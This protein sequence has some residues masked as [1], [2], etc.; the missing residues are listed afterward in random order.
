MLQNQEKH[1]T[2][3]PNSSWAS[4]H[5]DF[6][7][8]DNNYR[9]GWELCGFDYHQTKEW[10]NAGFRPSESNLVNEWIELGFKPSSAKKL[11]QNGL[12]VYDRFLAAYACRKGYE[13]SRFSKSSL[14]EELAKDNFCLQSWFD[15]IYPLDEDKLKVREISIVGDIFKLIDGG[16]FDVSEYSNLERAIID[17]T[18]S[19]LKS[20]LKKFAY[21]NKKT[22]YLSIDCSSPGVEIICKSDS[23][24]GD[25]L[26][27][28]LKPNNLLDFTQKKNGFFNEI[29]LKKSFLSGELNLNN[30]PE[31]WFRIFIWPNISNYLL[32]IKTQS[33][34][35]EFIKPYLA[36]DWLDHE[37]PKNAYFWR[38]IYYSEEYTH[39]FWTNYQKKR[40]EVNKL[41]I[42]NNLFSSLNLNDFKNLKELSC[43]NNQLTELILCGL[44]N[45]ELLYCKSNKLGT[46]DLSKNYNL[47]VVDCSENKLTK[48]LLSKK[49]KIVR[50]N[51]KSNFL[52]D[53]NSLHL[54]TSLR[55]LNIGDNNFPKQKLNLFSQLNNLEELFIGNRIEERIKKGIWNQFYGSLE[56]LK[57]LKKLKELD[58]SHTTIDCG[59]EFLPNNV[60]HV[61]Y[62]F[63]YGSGWEELKK[64]EKRIFLHHLLAR[65]KNQ[66]YWI[67]LGFDKSEIIYWLE[68]GLKSDDYYFAYFSRRR[69]DD[70][71]LT[72][73]YLLDLKLKCES[74]GWESI[75]PLFVPK[76]QKEWEL[77]SFTYWE[78]QAWIDLGL[79]IN[80]YN[81]VWW[82]KNVKDENL[83]KFP[84]SDKKKLESDY[85]EFLSEVEEGIKIGV[86]AIWRLNDDFFY[87]LKR[88]GELS[89]KEE[90]NKLIPNDLLREQYIENGL[91]VNHCKSNFTID[92]CSLC[93]S[94]HFKEGFS[95]WTS[96]NNEIDKFIQKSQLKASRQ[97]DILEWIPYE[98]LSKIKY[99][100]EGG[101]GEL[102]RA[103]WDAGQII[104]WDNYGG[105][106][107]RLKDC[108]GEYSENFGY[109][110]DVALKVVKNSKN[111]QTSFV[112]FL[113]EVNFLKKSDSAKVTRCFGVSQDP[114]TNDYIIVMEYMEEGNVREYLRREYKKIKL[115]D[116]LRK[117]EN[118][119][120][121]LKS[122]HEKDLVHKDLH[123][124]N[125]LINETSPDGIICAIT[126][127]G[128]CCPVDESSQGKIF[129]VLPYV[130][131]E[132]LQNQPYTPV[133]DVY[134]VGIII[135]ELL[136]NAYPY[137]D[138]F[139]EE[140]SESLALKICK[141]S[142]PSL[143][144]TPIPQ[145]LKNL[146]KS[147]WD[148]NP[149]KRPKAEEL[150]KT[151]N[152]FTNIVWYDKQ[153]RRKHGSFLKEFK[154]LER[155][156][157]TWSQNTPYRIHPDT[158]TH[159][160]PI[161]TAEIARLY[162]A[163][164]E[165]EAL[166]LE[167]KK[168]EQEI[169]QSLTE[170]QKELI[171]IF[172]Q[173]RKKMIKDTSDQEA[174]EKALNLEDQLLDEKGFSE[175]NI[176]KIID[177]CKRLDI[178]QEKLQTNIE[179]PTKT[180]F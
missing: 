69:S 88:E 60:L 34:D 134:S 150:N 7:K 47:K 19:R 2:K 87:S 140:S 56:F 148:S 128:L 180:N 130:A 179:I 36:Q 172:I 59:V 58:I 159:S 106:W 121:A 118:L 61:Y 137:Y 24:T 155:E 94:H 151:V 23:A 15:L 156:Y 57:N 17:K 170:E 145:E 72:E 138:S 27:R 42:N 175:E 122:I 4:I 98:Q 67:E 12:S 161:N 73:S 1:K 31:E 11:I 167:L 104:N 110:G 82:L 109:S 160:Q 44:E 129:G 141:G 50:L 85:H 30:Q 117:I 154:K 127:L 8:K 165:Q 53:L 3:K 32:V 102:Y 105:K 10:I 153:E 33:D 54:S 99:I 16:E 144:E 20:P 133:S 48:L 28:S 123:S 108:G 131:P 143:D 62:G 126:D 52:T 74:L 177:Y 125:V 18:K 162:Q 96:R 26:K 124:G 71:P 100:T 35:S 29:F 91:C 176:E 66:K 75:N 55:F 70:I 164:Q 120:S 21:R 147:C 78:A 149:E 93:M 97:S 37:C 139:K 112:S 77:G 174:K 22:I 166:A 13:C 38:K 80:D 95:E 63:D 49:N 132:V 107:K 45:L 86:E 90:L 65:S 158:I 146:I 111:S 103:R 101:F 157:N 79:S 152:D 173:T 40:N 64:I 68:V 5:D 142:R 114:K 116:K 51:C 84:N 92:W 89:N 163:S 46:L 14:K 41:L 76:I 169:K 136:A 39:E 178:E 25:E 9:Q 115:E 43:P 81:Y 168:I 6:L 171:N 83:K 135:Y 113:Q 119:S